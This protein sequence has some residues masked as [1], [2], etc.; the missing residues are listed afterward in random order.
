MIAGNDCCIYESAFKDCKALETVKLE[1]GVYYLGTN[2]FLGCS[3]LKTVYISKTVKDFEENALNGCDNV[4][5]QVTESTEGHKIVEE[6]GYDFEIVARLSFF[7][8]IAVFFENLFS[9]LF[10]WII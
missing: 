6:S 2:A 7:E 5:F 3:E 8:R 9:I 1:E 10:G 4:T